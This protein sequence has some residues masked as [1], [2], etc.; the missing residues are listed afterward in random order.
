MNDVPLMQKLNEKL[1]SNERIFHLSSIELIKNKTV[2]IK[3]NISSSDYDNVLDYVLE[4]R[5]KEIIREVIPKDFEVD[6]DFRKVFTTENAVSM[7]VTEFFYN[8]YPSMFSAIKGKAQKIIFDSAKVIITLPVA[9][10]FHAFLSETG[11]NEKL[12]QYLESRFIERFEV[13]FEKIE[14]DSK[15]E[16]PEIA[17][18]NVISLPTVNIKV[19][20]PLYGGIPKAPLYISEVQ[21]RK[22][23]DNASVCGKIF[24]FKVFH[25]KTDNR[26]FYIFKL[27][28]TTETITAK[29]FIPKKKQDSNNNDLPVSDEEKSDHNDSLK[30]SKKQIAAENL[31]DG[32]EV[33]VEGRIVYD[34]RE[35]KYCMLV[36]RISLCEIDYSSIDTEPKFKELPEDYAVIRPVIFNEVA[37]EAVDTFDYS[38]LLG[39]KFAVVDINKDENNTITSVAML[40][41]VDGKTQEYME[42]D[43]VKPIDR[44]TEPYKF[45]QVIADFYLF[46]YGLDVYCRDQDSIKVFLKEA[47][48]NLYDFKNNFIN[49]EI[50][51][52][53]VF[54]DLKFSIE[55]LCKKYNIEECL[56]EK[57][58]VVLGKLVRR[59]IK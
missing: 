32:M 56:A 2:Y 50:L 9:G 44:Y 18:A 47:R 22:E 52:K 37:Q 28:D 21:R 45:S 16:L 8:N 30:K 36:N 58:V 55:K 59:L 39:T 20:T 15:F 12:Q 19:I 17:T 24:D 49:I 3:F 5:V 33:A 11:A 1:S 31:R 51:A 34:E 10:H 13:I 29:I 14:D 25:S 38:F 46:A 27:D 4:E 6:I 35:S 54:P 43:F 57:T 40:K 53:K 26:P 7:E 42:S 41:F 48:N 23:Q